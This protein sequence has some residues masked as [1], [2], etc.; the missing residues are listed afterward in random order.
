MP[1]SCW[2][3]TFTVWQ[4]DQD[5]LRH[6]LINR[7]NGE[8]SFQREMKIETLDGHARDV[9]ITIGRPDATSDLDLNFLAF[10]DITERNR[11]QARLSQMQTEAQRE[12]Q[13][14]IDTIPTK[15]VTFPA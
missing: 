15:V 1:A 10:V 3:P 12:L 7:W 11:M 14:T 6:A 8:D 9:L 4:R 13:L 5:A 2:G